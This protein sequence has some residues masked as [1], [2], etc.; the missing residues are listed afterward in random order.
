MEQEKKTSPDEVLENLKAQAGNAR[1]RNNLD[2]LHAVCQEQ[3]ERGSHDFTLPTIGRLSEKAGGPKYTTIR[4]QGEQAHRFQ[5]LIA[6]WASWSGGITKKTAKCSDAGKNSI[7]EQLRRYNIDAALV[8]LI[9]RMEAD[10]RKAVNA[11]NLLKSKEEII[12][13]RR[14]NAP[15]ARQVAPMEVLPPVALSDQEREA[16]KAVLSDTFLQ[17]EGWTIDNAGRIKNQKGRTLFKA[18]FV[19]AL[20]KMIEVR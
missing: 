13:D 12:I 1:S 11:L 5:T 19:P 18:G 3:K 8:A 4:T 9:G 2:I 6:A 16:L 17:N 14:K 15:Q 7:V 20:R 10:Y